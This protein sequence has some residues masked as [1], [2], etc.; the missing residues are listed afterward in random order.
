MEELLDCWTML[1]GEIGGFFWALRWPIAVYAGLYAVGAAAFLL[2]LRFKSHDGRLIVGRDSWAYM[3]AH[4]MRYGGH[5][6]HKGHQG[7]ICTFYARMFNMLL[8][9]WPFLLVYFALA[10]T[11]GSAVTFAFASHV[12]YPSLREEWFVTS[13]ALTRVPLAV[14]TIPAALLLLAIM[15]RGSLLRWLSVA[16][17]AVLCASPVLI[18]LALTGASYFKVRRSDGETASAVREVIVAQKQRFCKF[19]QFE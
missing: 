11:F 17:W 2:S 19:I 7:S 1:A 16:A 4:P 12:V 14:V 5:R 13:R 8:V 9:V 6:P 3:I 15:F 18:A 10:T